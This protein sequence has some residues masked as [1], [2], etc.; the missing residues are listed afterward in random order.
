MENGKLSAIVAIKVSLATWEEFDWK[1]KTRFVKTPS[2]VSKCVENP[3]AMYCWR[4]R[5]MVGEHSHVF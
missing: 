5:G 4:G 3:A 2:V 1:T